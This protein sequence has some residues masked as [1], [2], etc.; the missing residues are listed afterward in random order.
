MVKTATK[1]V[2]VIVKMA[3]T[4]TEGLAANVSL[5]GL[6][7]SVIVLDGVEHLDA[8]LIQDCVWNV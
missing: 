3:V 8:M 2:L 5:G 1:T 7:N 6:E 4:E